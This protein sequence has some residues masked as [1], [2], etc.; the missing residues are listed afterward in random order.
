[1]AFAR[2]AFK[3]LLTLAI[4]FVVV[5]LLLPSSTTVSRSIDIQAPASQVFPHINNL[6][7][8]HAWSPWSALDPNTRYSFEGPAEGVGARMLWQSAEGEVGTGSAQIIV[9]QRDQSVRTELDF[10]GKG[11]G[12]AQFTLVP[13]SNGN[14][15]V[16]WRFETDF[17][18]DIFSRYIGLMMDSLI[19][20][21]YQTG[22]ETLK[23]RVEAAG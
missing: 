16:T 6:R 8:F 19:G 10:G 9:S 15:Q 23:Q 21:S 17:G 18:W 11:H 3:I 20:P 1:M 7:K 14:T 12:F 22:L 13:Q 5:G 4:A 2:I